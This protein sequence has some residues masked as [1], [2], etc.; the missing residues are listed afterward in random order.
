MSVPLI[1]NG[2]TRLLIEGKCFFVS[3]YILVKYT[4][5]RNEHCHMAL[6]TGFACERLSLNPRRHRKFEMKV[7][8]D[9]KRKQKMIGVLG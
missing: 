5:P 3:K 6:K 7:L 4:F 2:I 8:V 9:L 1:L